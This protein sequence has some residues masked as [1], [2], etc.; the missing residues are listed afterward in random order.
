VNRRVTA[1]ASGNHS[2]QKLALSFQADHEK[3]CS[4]LYGVAFSFFPG[5]VNGESVPLDVVI[6]GSGNVYKLMALM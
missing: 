4:F 6:I 2:L 3:T 1:F 5:A